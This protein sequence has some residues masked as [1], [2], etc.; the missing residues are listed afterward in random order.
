MFSVNEQ[1]FM[2]E[3]YQSILF[4]SNSKMIIQLKKKQIEIIG[5][6]LYLDYFSNVEIRG[7]GHI[8][9]VRFMDCL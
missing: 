1:G 7:K 6:S 2:I 5:K 4:L 3:Q 9:E 8:Q